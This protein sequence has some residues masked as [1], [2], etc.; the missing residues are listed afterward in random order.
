MCRVQNKIP[1][2]ENCCYSSAQHRSETK[3]KDRAAF[4]FSFFFSPSDNQAAF[5]V[6]SQ[7]SAKQIHAA[8]LSC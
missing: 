5:I 4:F 6:G 3:E 7:P 2:R 1:R 8:C